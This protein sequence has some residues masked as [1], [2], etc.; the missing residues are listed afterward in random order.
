MTFSVLYRKLIGLPFILFGVCSNSFYQ[1]L[2]DSLNLVPRLGKGKIEHIL[3]LLLHFLLYWSIPQVC[4]I[5]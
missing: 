2:L 5:S 1:V 4:V 3:A